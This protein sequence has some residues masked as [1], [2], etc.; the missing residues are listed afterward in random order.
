MSW[1][2]VV[3]SSHCKLDLKM[4]CMVIRSDDTKRVSLDKVSMILVESTAVSITGC[5]ISELT[6]RKIRLVFCDEKYSPC[7][8]M[9][10]L[11]GSHDCSAKIRTQ[12]GWSSET[13]AFIWTAIVSE[14]IRNQSI[15]LK[16]L[17]HDDE[18]EMLNGYIAEMELNDETN[19]EGHAAKVYFNAL[20][21]QCFSRN[22]DN[23]MNA[24]L[25]YGYSLILSAVNR[26]VCA[27]G[28]L[29][30][31]GLF[32]DNM[33]NYYNL[34]CDLME[35]FR[36]IVDR[37]VAKKRYTSFGTEEKHELIRL[38]ETQVIIAGQEQYLQNAIKIY[39]RSVF[40]ALNGNDSS[41]I[42]FFR[43]CG[44]EV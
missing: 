43:F 10:P 36:I 42:R 13:K 23:S 40:D 1:R 19:R 7:A 32:H 17:G 5:L 4:G 8:E 39:C 16:M 22:N 24:A 28:Y 34:S 41:L 33:F 18:A 37:L 44:D 31:I 9:T 11:Y 15:H 3:V 12:I 29:T 25:N 38:F 26:E 35:P 6:R 20:F 27:C 14:K 2:T 21:G 30:Q